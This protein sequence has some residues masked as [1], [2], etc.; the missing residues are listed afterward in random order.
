MLS[1]A[2][3]AVLPKTGC[4]CLHHFSLALFLLAALSVVAK[5]V[6]PAEPVSLNDAIRQ[7]AERIAAIPNLKG[8][9]QL[10]VHD[11]A[12][13]D[14]SEGQTWIAALR[15]ELDLRKLS[16]TEESAAPLLRVGAT[17]TPTQI[18]LRS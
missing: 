7:L 13:F 16:I 18:V 14:A 15:R 12:A 10:E 5:P 2:K 4:S 1:W 11:D 3:N 17:E 9:I 6:K 8:P